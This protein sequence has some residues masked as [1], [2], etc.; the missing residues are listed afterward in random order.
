MENAQ[1]LANLGKVSSGNDGD[2]NNN[3]NKD[4]RKQTDQSQDKGD[5]VAGERVKKARGKDD[6]DEGMDDGNDNDDKDNDDD[7]KDM[8]KKKTRM[9][10][11]KGEVMDAPQQLAQYYM[12]VNTTPSSLAPIFHPPTPTPPF[13]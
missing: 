9:S 8:D 1:D 3:N 6:E 4:Q 7:D 5:E 12:M 2:N 11:E 10:L 13:R